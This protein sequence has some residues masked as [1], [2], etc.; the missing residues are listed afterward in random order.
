MV[1]QAN[2]VI[3]RASPFP[4]PTGWCCYLLLCGDGGYYCGISEDLRQR[5]KDHVCGKGSRQTRS[6]RPL[7]LVWYE[8]H[9]D[10]PSARRRER[11]IKNWGHAKKEALSKGRLQIGRAVWIPLD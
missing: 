3:P 10:A 8:D 7:A 5:C 2:P 4:F 1:A 11:Q 9:P 6:K